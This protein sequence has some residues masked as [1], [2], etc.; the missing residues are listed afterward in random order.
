MTRNLRTLTLALTAFVLIAVPAS[1]LAKHR[2]HAA[3]DLNQAVGSVTAF[4]DGTLAVEV[5]DGSTITG[6]VVPRTRLACR[7]A[8][9]PAPAPPVVTA[10]AARRGPAGATGPSGPGEQGRGSGWGWGRR[11]CDPAAI[12]VGTKVL[13]ADLRLTA[14]GPAWRRVVFLT[15]ATGTTGP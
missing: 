7:T 13:A 8:V 5:A 15:P 10:L 4:A 1:S 2:A 6:A 12:R 9:A 11:T 14:N 3:Q